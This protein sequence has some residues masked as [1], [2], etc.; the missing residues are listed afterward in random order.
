MKLSHEYNE[1]VVGLVVTD[2]ET[3]RSV[4]FQFNPIESNH[5]EPKLA[6]KHSCEGDD[7][8]EVFTVEELE[9][10]SDYVLDLD[11]AEK[12][13]IEITAIT[14]SH[15][16]EEFENLLTKQ[17]CIYES[18][19]L[20]FFKKITW[21]YVIVDN[22]DL[23]EA[24]ETEEDAQAEIDSMDDEDAFLC[25]IAHMSNEEYNAI[26]IIE[27]FA[28]NN[29]SKKEI[30]TAFHHEM[31]SESKVFVSEQLE[32]LNDSNNP[33]D[34]AYFTYLISNVYNVADYSIPQD[35]DGESYH[36]DVEPKTYREFAVKYINDLVYSVFEK[37]INIADLV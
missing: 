37:K 9:I 30:I 28:V 13:E 16:A 35:P 31:N 21:V 20:D 19:I 4:N 11:N 23:G 18:D 29:Y 2:L 32:L 3:N 15:L 8:A 6:L 12:L 17:G 34:S 14:Y 25:S 1:Y 26:A 7:T 36:G 10:I 27:E 5:P 22:G 33:V 24:F